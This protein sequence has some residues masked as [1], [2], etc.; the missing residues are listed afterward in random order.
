MKKLLLIILILSVQ[1]QNLQSQSSIDV[2]VEGLEECLGKENFQKISELFAEI[3]KKILEKI[4][5]SDN[6]YFEFSIKLCKDEIKNDFFIINKNSKLDSLIKNALEIGFWYIDE[7]D[8]NE[9]IIIDG[10]EVE[11][12]PPGGKSMKKNP[13]DIEKIYLN[14]ES[15]FIS[16]SRIFTLQKTVSTYY[17]LYER[18]GIANSFVKLCG[19]Y[20]IIEKEDYK[21][22]SVKYFIS[23]DVVL[24][25]MLH[26]NKYEKIV[27]NKY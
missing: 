14:G 7:I 2:Y 10:K 3:D 25:R 5:E 6:P 16:C 15:K 12:I 20:E 22:N 23:I 18:L 4:N 13:E 27:K 1:I 24:Q 9:P 21:L 26:Q 8:L 19:L 17:D 11:I